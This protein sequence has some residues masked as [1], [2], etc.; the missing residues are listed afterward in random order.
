MELFS[1]FLFTSVFV[2]SIIFHFLNFLYFNKYNFL[3]TY[4][5]TIQ[6]HDFYSELIIKANL[7]YVS[8]Y[9]KNIDEN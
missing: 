6:F 5:C 3:T 1:T 2:T 7:F 9:K 8:K 4:S